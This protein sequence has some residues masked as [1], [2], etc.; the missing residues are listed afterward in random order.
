[1][2][3]MVKNMKLNLKSMLKIFMTVVSYVLF[4]TLIVLEPVFF[5]SLFVTI[6][7]YMYKTKLQDTVSLL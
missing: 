4:I 5:I 1:M 3:W 6:S 7:V 2:S